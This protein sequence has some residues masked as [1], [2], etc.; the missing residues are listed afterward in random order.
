MSLLVD[1]ATNALDPA[2]A[3]AAARRAAGTSRP[4]ATRLGRRGLLVALLLVAGLLLTSA[5]VQAHLR[6]PAAARARDALIREVQAQSRETDRLA[7]QLAALRTSTTAT[8][9]RL[10]AA[11][12]SGQALS[13][14][15]AALE[16]A[17][18]TVAVTGPGLQV[19]LADAPPAADGTS[20][21]QDRDLQEVINALW[22]AGAEAIAVNGERVTAETAIRSAGEA[23]LVDLRPVTSPYV[24]DAI[25]DPVGLET[26]FGGSTTAARFHTYV[27]LYG[28]GFGYRRMTHLALPAASSV[29]LRYAV[30]APGGTK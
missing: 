26:A 18:G 5:A 10:L 11:S 6:A 4:T 15:V 30:P 29:E 27:Q 19:R 17:V 14:Q 23:I 28:I 21:I 20:R 22:T 25:G 7:A 8:R 3:E 16:Q 2:Y 24:V 13:G 1:I 12:A 9:D